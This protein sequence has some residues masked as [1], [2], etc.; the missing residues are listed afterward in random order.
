MIPVAA[1]AVLIS[2][3]T[4]F[5]AAPISA[6]VFSNSSLSGKY[7]VRHVEF[8]TDTNNNVTDAR[9]IIGAMTFNGAGGYSFSGQQVV[10]T[11]AAASFTVSGT[12]SMSSSGMLTLTN[13]QKTTATINARFGAEAVIG[14]S[15]EIAGNTFDL[16]AAIPAPTKTIAIAGVGLSWNATDFELTSAS[17][18]QVRDSFVAF[19]LDGNGN[20]TAA[21]VTGH[22]ANYDSGGTVN[23]AIG[24]GVYSVNGDG[25]GT[26]TF[27]NPSGVSGAEAMM[28]G[29]QRM[30]LVSQ[31]GNVLIAGTPGAHDILL[32]VL[33]PTGTVTLTPA[34]S[35]GIR[36]DSSGSSDSYIGSD[37]VIA[38]AN[39]II[40]SR[41]LHESTSP[42]PVNET[43]AQ[44]YTL[45]P[46]G[47]G[48]TGP[49]TIAAG[50]TAFVGANT[51]S[52]LDPTGYEI[53][54][55]ETL[56]T[57]SGS[58]VFVNPQGVVNAASNS[59][60]GNPLSPGEF[61]AIYGT[62]L[63]PQTMTA[64]PPYPNTVA[65]VS[66]SIGGLPA[67]VY[68]VSA[69]QLNCLVP[70]EVP[71][72]STSVSV[73]VNN[74]GQMSNAVSV[75][76]SATSPGIFSDN[77]SGT[78]DG[79]IVHGLTGL[80]VTP[81]NPAVK[82]ETLAMYLTGLGAVQNSV[83]DGAAPNPPGPDAATAQL[84]VYVNGIA[85]AVNY[86]GLNP[87]YPGLYQ[88]NF[89]VPAT[90]TVSGELPVAVETTDSFNDQISLSVR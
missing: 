10:G 5:S 79:A 77:E 16:F 53:A 57:L 52:V 25:T 44:I 27:P 36:V 62:G 64:L 75:P 67:T 35:G 69:G 3:I 89:V 23:Q 50:T 66:V 73:I 17:T 15:T 31:T 14:S 85:A 32:A 26:I 12:Y 81:S 58:G 29:T 33:A 76:F 39:R 34:W 88:I 86:A 68:L 42:T 80:L 63:A 65:G 18:A 6:Q 11:G 87:V 28:G 61:I 13:P 49:T 38:S 40:A 21:N 55:G 2:L 47:T 7:F 60:V 43:A 46:N 24:P 59:P 70:Y 8:S 4:M 56:P 54:F 78:G 84:A 30:L 9:S 37:T 74:N 19:T 51:G 72:G 1:R 20:L 45:A 41:R 22:A 90:L 71:P 82:G 83:A 48:S